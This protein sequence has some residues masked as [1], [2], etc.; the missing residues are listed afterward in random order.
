M[1]TVCKLLI[2]IL[3]SSSVITE[4]NPC[5]IVLGDISAQDLNPF[6]HRAK[7]FVELPVDK[8]SRLSNEYKSRLIAAL[9]LYNHTYGQTDKKGLFRFFDLP[10]LILKS[11]DNF[12]NFSYKNAEIFKF[13]LNQLL[14]EKN[15][16][17]KTI[18]LN[19][20]FY[21]ASDLVIQLKPLFTELNEDIRLSKVRLLFSDSLYKDSEYHGLT[22]EMAKGDYYRLHL[23]LFGDGLIGHQLNGPVHLLPR[24][25]KATL[26]GTMDRYLHLAREYGVQNLETGALP[27]SLSHTITM[28]PRLE[29][30]LH[31]RKL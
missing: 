4:A 25:Y 13:K 23:T 2:L 18:D 30:L 7:S 28:G 24:Y 10:L 11:P 15:A 8:K 26:F 22:Q 21:L 29:L 5:F 1:K 27:L 20:I 12:N 9:K 16:K 14:T 6:N 3:L 31:F 19:P 17:A